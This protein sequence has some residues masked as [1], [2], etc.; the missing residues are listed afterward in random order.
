MDT[1]RKNITTKAAANEWLNANFPNYEVIEW[2]G[3]GKS[4]D[5]IIL[6]KSRNVKFSYAFMRFRDKIQ[7][8]PDREFGMEQKE[9]VAKARKAM[10]DKYGVN[11]P[12]QIEEF[13]QK[14]VQTL[15]EKYGTE[16]VMFNKEF[17]ENLKGK[18]QKEIWRN[19]EVRNRILENRKKARERN[20][21]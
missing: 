4:K 11:S 9:I 3:N 18:M 10:I 5:T 16:N 2:G 7:K 1:K 21:K 6:D 14:A 20:D 17:V 8:N 13:R 12:L 15:K 19:E